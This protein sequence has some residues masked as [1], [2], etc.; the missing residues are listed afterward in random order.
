MTKG[1]CCGTCAY[2]K[3]YPDKDGKARIRKSE[4]YACNWVFPAFDQMNFPDSA[5][6]GRTG[7]FHDWPPRLSR[8]SPTEGENCKQWYPK[9]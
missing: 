1:R 6:M 4:T 5:E 7:T 2:L 8:M 9:V 3:V